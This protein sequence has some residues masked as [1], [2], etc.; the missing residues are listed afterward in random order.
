M[1]ERKKYT[2]WFW[3]G[4][5]PG[6]WLE[7]AVYASATWRSA[8][9]ET[10][11]RGVL[12]RMLAAQDEDGYLGITD[13][14]VRTRRHPM[15]GMDP[16]EL[17]FTLHALLSVFDEWGSEPARKAAM[18]I[19]DFFLASVKEGVAEFWPLPKPITIAG[20][21]VHYGMEG[22]LLLDPMMRLYEATGDKR[23]LD[24]C[25]WVLSSIDRWT[26][27]GTYSN[28][29]K[30][31]DGAMRL[32]DV[33]TKVHAHTLHMN[34]LGFL[35]LY[36]TTG[37][38]QLLRN[39]LGAWPAIMEAHRY[40]TGG[41]SLGESYREP[42]QLF[43]T[44]Q[45]VETCAS[46]SWL[47][48]NQ[49]LLEL[50][51]NPAHADAMESVIW[52][53]LF[54]AQT[55]ES[56]GYNYFCALNGW[57]PEGYFTGPNCC[58]SSGPRIMAMLPTFLYGA[59]RDA[60]FIDQYVPSRASLRMNGHALGLRV[61]ADY[62]EG[63]NAAVEITDLDAPQTFALNLR[64]PRW[65]SNPSIK[66]NGQP[67]GAASMRR[68]WKRGDRVE[69]SL[70]METKWVEG[71]YTNQGLAALTRGPLV[72][73]LETVWTHPEGFA[74]EAH[75][76][77]QVPWYAKDGESKTVPDAFAHVSRNLRP[78][79]TPK[80]AVGPVYTTEV[81]LT[82]GRRIEAMMLPFANLGRWYGS[83]AERARELV[84]PVGTRQ[85]EDLKSRVHPFAVWV[86]AR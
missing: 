36:E 45:T 33:Q 20:H 10:K 4:E 48:L 27:F 82:T 79:A 12:A 16:Y 53:H 66:V 60:V 35:R 7:A 11:A 56:D 59:S 43:N 68:E 73:C 50:T 71:D 24:W 74:A 3:L 2:D 57:K 32:N 13:P 63:P 51:G 39:V 44:G 83:E 37:D 77:P 19:G 15:R 1:L 34:M 61:S 26:V 85:G 9:L 80:D 76:M 86:K 31:A 8:A 22:S 6:K 64:I 72:Y 65:C 17:Y 29:G 40:I 75:A 25:R 52:N 41:V 49:R 23:Y 67:G 38:P 81:S 46:M 42:H 54:A 28:L 21:E 84:P 14:A 69:I 5:Q 18:R 58:S 62:P 47:I 78:A 70:P 55:W 30:V